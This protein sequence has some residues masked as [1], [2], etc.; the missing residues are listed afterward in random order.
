[1][2]GLHPELHAL[3]AVGEGRDSHLQQAIDG[4][5]NVGDLDAAGLADPRCIRR[6]Q[7]GPRLDPEN[8]VVAPDDLFVRQVVVHVCGVDVQDL[9]AQEGKR[10]DRIGGIERDEAAQVEMLFDRRARVLE[11][12]QRIVAQQESQLMIEIR[13]A[14]LV[15]GAEMIQP[16]AG[17]RAHAHADFQNEDF[18]RQPARGFEFLQQLPEFLD[19]LFDAFDVRAGGLAAGQGL[20]V[21]FSGG[22]LP[23]FHALPVEPVEF[24][25][26]AFAERLVILEIDATFAL[27]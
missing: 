2:P 3:R 7:V 8:P 25:N 1:M 4:R 10:L 12:R 6:R 24:P 26:D 27:R 17:V 21:A 11:R 23:V 20:F 14:R 9:V 18:L 16:Q 22:P 13:P 5:P 15:Q 19:G